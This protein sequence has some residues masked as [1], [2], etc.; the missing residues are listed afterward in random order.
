MFKAQF[1]VYRQQVGKE[2]L[3]G[4]LAEVD[5]FLILEVPTNTQL[6]LESGLK[7]LKED[8]LNAS[9]DNLAALEKF[10]T[11][12]IV[13]VNLPADF[14]LAMAYFNNNL[15][16][17]ITYNQAE[18]YFKRKHSLIKLISGTQSASGFLQK[19]DILVLTTKNSIHNLKD[20]HFLNQI[21]E[22]KDYQ[23]INKKMAANILENDRNL[24]FLKV[25]FSQSQPNKTWKS[26]QIIRQNIQT[27]LATTNKRKL[28]TLF[29]VVGLLLIFIWSVLFGHKRRLEREQRQ[30]ITT[31]S[32]QFKQKLNA[33]EEASF[34]DVKQALSLIEQ[35]KTDLT[36]LKAQFNSSAYPEIKQLEQL[37]VDKENRLRKREEKSAVEFFDLKIDQPNAFGA[38][39]VLVNDNLVILDNQ[40]SSVYFLSIRKKS[41]DKKTTSEFKKTTLITA[42]DK[43]VFFYLDNDGI[44]KNDVQDKT[45]KIIDF[46]PSWGVIKQLESYNNNLYLLDTDKNQIYKYVATDNGYDST[47]YFSN[48]Q[49]IGLA[50]IKTMA[51]DGSVYLADDNY[52][53][54]YT[55]G[56]RESFKINYPQA[57]FKIEKILTYK[58]TEKI[59]LWNKAKSTLIILH[60][61]GSYL[62][63]IH[64]DYIGR[65]SDVVFFEDNFYLLIKNKIYKISF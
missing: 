1:Q 24:I 23:E 11:Q 58:E 5:F 47:A 45:K 25:L 7:Q 6:D 65:S 54:K 12:E 33:A 49:E 37:I 32:Q 39:M 8:C 44:Y 15:L 14:S 61:D 17:L 53:V 46:D 62:K 30:K 29:L 64:S 26:V 16:Y 52:V 31:F 51:I 20:D 9:W 38:K 21:F 42:Q 10:F 59:A 34:F 3:N 40:N 41:L 63:E 27:K 28:I 56:L 2:I 22:S 57:D 18:I 48:N 19:G 4:Y 60:K 55:S 43:N 13:K 50:T 35:A 36:L